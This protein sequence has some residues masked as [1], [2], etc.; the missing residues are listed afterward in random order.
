[1]LMSCI[2]L[3][4]CCLF[5]LKSI[6]SL[7]IPWKSNQC[8]TKIV[9]KQPLIGFQQ[10]DYSEESW[11]I[12]RKTS[13]LDYILNKARQFWNGNFPNSWKSSKKKLRHG[14]FI[15]FIQLRLWGNA[16]VVCICSSKYV[17]LKVLQILQENTC[18]GV[19]FW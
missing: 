18:V 12:A 11:K 16:E 4:I 13:V 15:H 8:E 10:Y 5:L 19:S 6:A 1:M 9:S 17:F 3:M 7:M 14:C 2:F